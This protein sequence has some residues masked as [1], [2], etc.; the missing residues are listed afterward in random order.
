M[1]NPHLNGVWLGLDVSPSFAFNSYCNGFPL[2]QTT[3]HLGIKGFLVC[4]KNQ[5]QTI[6]ASESIHQHHDN[7]REGLC[8]E[9]AGI[10]E[11][12]SVLVA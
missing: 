11:G 8:G 1:L 5:Y 3:P 6:E 12:T 2:A 9:D 10:T 4:L 7:P